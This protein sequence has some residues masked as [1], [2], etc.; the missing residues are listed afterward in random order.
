MIKVQLVKEYKEFK[1]GSVISVSAEEASILIADK[2]ATS[3]NASTL[4]PDTFID[5][6]SKAIS[7]SPKLKYYD[8][9]NQQR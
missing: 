1:S 4:K 3:L 2:I 6:E 9:K 5:C 7:A 8:K